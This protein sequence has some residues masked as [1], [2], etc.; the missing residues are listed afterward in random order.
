MER[1][2]GPLLNKHK[3]LFAFHHSLTHSLTHSL[4]IKTPLKVFQFIMDKLFSDSFSITSSIDR[5]EKE[6]PFWGRRSDLRL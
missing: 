5:Q 3:K 4:K 6:T 1:K 2:Q